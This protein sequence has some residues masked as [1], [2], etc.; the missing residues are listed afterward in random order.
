MLA[1]N[2]PSRRIAERL[3]LSVHTVNNTLARVYDKLG[4]RGRG[5]PATVF[6]VVSTSDVRP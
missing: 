4:L 1:T 6:T 5:E 2:P 3:G